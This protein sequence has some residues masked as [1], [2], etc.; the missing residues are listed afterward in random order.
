MTTVAKIAKFEIVTCLGGH[1]AFVEVA[2]AVEDYDIDGDNLQN[3]YT[4]YALAAAGIENYSCEGCYHRAW[5]VKFVEWVES[6]DYVAD[7]VI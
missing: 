6:S 3:K 2:I 5:H 1:V 7:Y 4:S